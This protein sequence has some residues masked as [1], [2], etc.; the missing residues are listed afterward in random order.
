MFLDAPSRRLADCCTA[1]GIALTDAHSAIADAHATAELLGHYLGLLEGARR[2]PWQEEI[3]LADAFAGPRD[4]PRSAARLLERTAAR[5]VR[6]DGWL[7]RILPRIPRTAD[8]RIDS[9]LATL[10]LALLDGVLAEH[11]KDELVAV[12][13]ECGLSRGA[14]LELHAG[15]LWAMAEV[16]LADGVVTADP[17]SLSGNAAA[18]RARGIPI[19]TEDAFARMLGI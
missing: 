18:A 1:S 5:S 10:E 19:V 6:P 7:D 13:Q 12:A 3:E 15:Y 9:Y 17:N 8:S 16:A 2:L 14:V 4:L 11:E